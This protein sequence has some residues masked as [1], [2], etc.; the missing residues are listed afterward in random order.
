M[1]RKSIRLAQNFLKDPRL[2]AALVARAGLRRQDT[3]YEIGPGK[4]II[5]R[6]LAK[7]CARVIAVE[8][9][10]VLFARLA[11][12][13]RNAAHVELHNEDFLKH[14]I[15]EHEFRVFSA[16]PYNRTADIMRAI[17]HAKR[18]PKTAHLIVQR[19]AALK[20]AGL[21]RASQCSLIAYPWWLIDIVTTLKRTDFDPEPGVDSVLLR[22]RKRGPA[23]V[24]GE[25]ARLYRR[26]VREGFGGAKASLKLN[27]RLVFTY[28]QWGSLARNLRFELKAKPTEL[29]GRQWLGLFQFLK[30]GL[31]RSHIELPAE[32]RVRR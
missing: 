2:A 4:G 22:A 30:E 32:W 6:E 24:A 23:L 20:Y 16:I 26:F 29:T 27:L 25:D 1:A 17:L 3:V 9:D 11:E 28:T 31:A 13:F 10:P 5:T 7:R 14:R 18:P 15:R 19:E 21:P 8:L 12:E